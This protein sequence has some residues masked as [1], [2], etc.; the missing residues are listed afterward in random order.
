LADYDDETIATY[1]AVFEDRAAE[2]TK[3]KPD[4]RGEE[5]LRNASGS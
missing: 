1:I 4:A 2:A 3:K 5:A